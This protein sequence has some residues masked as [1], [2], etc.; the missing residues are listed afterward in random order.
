MSQLPPAHMCTAWDLIVSMMRVQLI[1]LACHADN[2]T[3]RLSPTANAHLIP[4]L[5]DSVPGNGSMDEGYRTLI[6]HSILVSP[7]TSARPKR[8]APLDSN[9]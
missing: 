4:G 9:S 6:C 8:R 7:H 5:W 1:S 2:V 3:C